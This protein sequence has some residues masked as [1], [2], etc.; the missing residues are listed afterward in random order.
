MAV[1]IK[2]QRQHEE[3]E[4]QLRRVEASLFLGTLRSTISPDYNAHIR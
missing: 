3:Y 4:N 2:I 1:T